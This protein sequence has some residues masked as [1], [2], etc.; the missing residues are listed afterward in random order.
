LPTPK[1]EDYEEFFEEHCEMELRAV[2]SLWRGTPWRSRW[3]ATVV[4]WTPNSAASWLIVA[5]A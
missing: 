4:R 1:F 3:A 5:P 2:G